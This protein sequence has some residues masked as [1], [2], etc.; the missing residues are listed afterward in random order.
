VRA[1]LWKE[2]RE[3][4]KWAAIALIPTGATAGVGIQHDE[5]LLLS[6]WTAAA[7]AFCFG[8]LQT[9]LEV[10]QNQWAF[11]IHRAVSPS[12]IWLGK[13]IVGQC[14]YLLVTG[15]PLLVVAVTYSVAGIERMPWH[16]TMVIPRVAL[17]IA[18]AGFYWGGMLVAVRLARWYGSRVLPLALPAVC[19]LLAAYW[20]TSVNP[21][22]SLGLLAIILSC[23]AVMAVAAWGS[24]VNS[25]ETRGQPKAGAIALGAS[26]FT[27]LSAIAW[28]GF[29][30]SFGIAESLYVRTLMLGE[31]RE[32]SSYRVDQHG[33]VW[34]FRWGR[35]PWD[36]QPPVLSATSTE[37][38]SRTLSPAEIDAT[39]KEAPLHHFRYRRQF[40]GQFAPMMQYWYAESAPLQWHFLPA[41]GLFVGYRMDRDERG[42]ALTRLARWAGPDGFTPADERPAARFGRNLGITWNYQWDREELATGSVRWNQQILAFEDG[43]YEIDFVRESVRRL[44]AAPGDDSIRDVSVA[45]SDGGAEL[46]I[47]HVRTLR[48]FRTE[49]QVLGSMTSYVLHDKERKEVELTTYVPTEIA[50]TITLPGDAACFPGYRVA[51]LPD[52]NVYEFLFE[53]DLPPPLDFTRVVE[54]KSDGTVLSR[55]DLPDPDVSGVAV[56]ACDLFASLTPLGVAAPL[57]A[58]DA[59]RQRAFGTG[60]PVLARMVSDKT[61]R[62]QSLLLILLLSASASGCVTFALAKRRGLIGRPRMVWSVVSALL[63]PSGV[64]LFITLC[65]RPARVTCP[66]CN[67]PRVVTRERCE[68]CSAPPAQPALTGTEILEIA[69]VA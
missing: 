46:A 62:S 28:T 50:R 60:P 21:F 42:L 22:G 48:F 18:G 47:G 61:G 8:L 17:I 24:F 38:P 13:S 45:F 49:Q 56:A 59:T 25:G 32:T 39:W 40:F 69:S 58:L 44:H 9:M 64:L 63:G 10:R 12:R 68:H 3:N 5:T 57:L 65:E 27:A 6:G 4:A 41:Y 19:Q 1:I 26:L 2:L 36:K 67:Q 14:L 29:G 15:G 37:D 66:A 11:L 54:M 23:N 31:R 52:R 30:V 43:V 51:W 20:L 34:Q 7:V 35:S 53:P 33:H 55:R 16:W